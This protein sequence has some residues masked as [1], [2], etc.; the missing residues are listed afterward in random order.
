VHEP[1]RREEILLTPFYWLGRRADSLGGLSIN[2]DYFISM[3]GQPLADWWG[4]WAF[5]MRRMTEL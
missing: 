4:G 1:H 3:Q 2:P 5:G